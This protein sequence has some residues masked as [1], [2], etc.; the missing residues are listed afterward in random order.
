LLAL[1]SRTSLMP[2]GRQ[3]YELRRSSPHETI[4]IVSGAHGAPGHRVATPGATPGD[5]SATRH[6]RGTSNAAALATRTAAQLYD[7]VESLRQQPDGGLL[8]ERYTPV[9]L[10]AM[11]VHG[12]RWGDSYTLLRPA[13]ATWPSH[14]REHAARFLGYGTVDA[15]RVSACTDQRATLIGCGELTDGIAHLYAIPLPPSLSGQRVYR[16]LTVTLAWITLPN[17]LHHR[18]HRADLW[19]DVLP[20]PLNIT[21]HEATAYAVKRGTVQHEIFEGERATPYTDPTS[22]EIKVNC[23]ALAGSL[24]DSVPYALVVSLEVEQAQGVLF[25]IPVYEEIRARLRVPI[26]IVPTH[27][28]PQP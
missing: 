26:P 6:I 3:L 12:A 1:S 17:S 13:L 15:T 5:L 22:L 10:K 20:N 7:T 27:R 8:D 11:V 2:G 28:A 14:E 4:L 18:Y 21:R 23:R 24:E 16:R 25:P 9:L 19:F